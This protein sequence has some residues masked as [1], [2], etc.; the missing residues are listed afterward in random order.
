VSAARPPTCLL[1]WHPSVATT[2][3][4]F[5]A[6]HIFPPRSVSRA[7][8]T[9][10]TQTQEWQRQRRVL[11]HRGQPSQDSNQASGTWSLAPGVLP[12][13]KCRTSS[14]LI[15]VRNLWTLWISSRAHTLR[16][17][18]TTHSHCFASTATSAG[19]QRLGNS[20]ADCQDPRSGHRVISLQRMRNLEEQESSLSQRNSLERTRSLI[21]GRRN[22]G[23]LNRCG[24]TRSPLK[25]ACS[26][27][28]I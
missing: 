6:L 21:Q 28:W 3:Q 18:S 23:G 1:P 9:M 2:L 15:Q 27:V 16:F 26:P 17:P 25:N 20:K 5:S 13:S 14:E 19:T 24:T 12:P 11:D 10:L 22:G 8:T 7:Q 4:H